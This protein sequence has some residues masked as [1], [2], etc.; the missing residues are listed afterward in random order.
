MDQLQYLTVLGQELMLAV[1]VS[2]SLIPRSHGITGIPY[3][4]VNALLM[5]LIMDVQQ[6]PRSQLVF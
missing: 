2:E 5:R 3:S 1:I 6:C 4:R